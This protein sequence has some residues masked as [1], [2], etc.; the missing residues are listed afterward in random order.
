MSFCRNVIVIYCD[1]SFE[2]CTSWCS[3]EL[4]IRTGWRRCSEGSLVYVHVTLPHGKHLNYSNMAVPVDIVGPSRCHRTLIR[5]LHDAIARVS[6]SGI[7]FLRQSGTFLFPS[8]CLCEAKKYQSWWHR[9]SHEGKPKMSRFD[10]MPTRWPY[11]EQDGQANST[12][13]WAFAR[14][15][16]NYLAYQIFCHRSRSCCRSLKIH[17]RSHDG[18]RF[19]HEWPD[20]FTIRFPLSCFHLVT[21]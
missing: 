10:M 12:R 6:F 14:P 9:W 20:V 18:L 2:S 3:A 21:I 16:C 17:W 7:V 19:P 11:E 4:L 13:Q 5:W 1:L 15:F 8:Y